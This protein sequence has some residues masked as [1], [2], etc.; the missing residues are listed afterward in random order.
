MEWKHKAACRTMGPELFFGKV[1]EGVTQRRLREKEAKRICAGCEVAMDCLMVGQN[2]EGIWGG[3]TD[4]ERRRATRR[5]RYTPVEV[6]PVRD[7]AASTEGWRLL[8]QRG[9]VTLFQ[10]ETD[11]SWHG[12]EWV[13]VRKETVVLKT[14]SLEDAYVTFGNMVD[15]STT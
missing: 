8:D 9:T 3:M 14:F 10:R 2:E 5:G 7:Q 15:S 4:W 6:K 12:Y 1:D 11:A 13:V